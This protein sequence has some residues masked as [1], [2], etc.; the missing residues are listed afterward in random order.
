M[1]NN[2][3]ITA[4][5]LRINRRTLDTLQELAIKKSRAT[6]PRQRITVRELILE[7]IDKYLREV[8]R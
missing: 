5:H 8:E 6:I 7:A 4:Y 1:T 3:E 2:D